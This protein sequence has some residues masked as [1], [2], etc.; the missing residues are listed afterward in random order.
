MARNANACKHSPGPAY[1]YEETIKYQKPPKFGFGTSAKILPVKPKYDFYENNRFID[2]PIEADHARKKRWLAPKIGTEPRMPTNTFEKTPG[3]Q[4]FPQ[5]KPNQKST[6]KFTFGFRRSG[7]GQDSLINKVSTTKSVGPGRY[8]PEASR[9]PSTKKDYPKWTLPKAGRASTAYKKL[10]KNQ[11]YDTRSS[12]GRQYLSKNK[13]G[14]STHFGTSN[15]AIGSS[16]AG[17]G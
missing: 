10:D 13:S 1:V 14:P 11:T 4:Y 15:R 12:V 6:E 17:M 8:V 7:G 2:D 9:N 16:H 3:P 5:G